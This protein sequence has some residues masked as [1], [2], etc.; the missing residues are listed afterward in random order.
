MAAIFK[1]ERL[2]GVQ[3]VG[4]GSRRSRLGEGS[5]ITVEGTQFDE[6]G[7][8]TVV[9]ADGEVGLGEIFGWL[10]VAELAVPPEERKWKR[11]RWRR[12]PIIIGR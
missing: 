10:A 4:L 2:M 6:K 8:P 7:N 1:T 11:M 12:T 3:R 9:V 5:Q